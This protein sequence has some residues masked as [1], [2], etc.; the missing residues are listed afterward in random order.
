M[1][2]GN[3]VQ[4]LLI[5]F[6]LWSLFFDPRRTTHQ[7][8]K[9]IIG[10]PLR[11]V[12]EWHTHSVTH[13]INKSYIPYFRRSMAGLSAPTKNYFFLMKEHFTYIRKTKAPACQSPCCCSRR[14]PELIIV[15][16]IIITVKWQSNVCKGHFRATL[17]LRLR[18]RDHCI[19]RSLIGW[20]GRDCLSSLHTRRWRPKGSKNI[21]W[22]KSLC[23][24]LY[25][26]PMDNV[27]WFAGICVKP[28]SKR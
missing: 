23:G 18:A 20:K 6:C 15:I 27:W 13:L 25:V 17:H 22:M 4:P 7:S 11:K 19:L 28:I 5:I 24:F 14:S 12:I 16:I 3:A 2:V 10:V 8:S 26:K 1:N 9:P 21:S